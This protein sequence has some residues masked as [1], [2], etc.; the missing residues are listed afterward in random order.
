MAGRRLQMQ[1]LRYVVVLR[2]ADA[3]LPHETTAPAPRVSDRAKHGAGVTRPG[4][5]LRDSPNAHR[6]WRRCAYES[7]PENAAISD[8]AMFVAAP[9]I[10]N[11]VQTHAAGV[12]C[13]CADLLE[14]HRAAH[15]RR[16]EADQCGR[17]RAQ[18][19]GI[20]ATPAVSSGSR[21]RTGVPVA[22][23]DLLCAQPTEYG[24]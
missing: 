17:T 6:R 20:I 8:L 3:E 13:A 22:S 16:L 24:E 5:D 10:G 14:P 4:G 19:A 23:A 7:V 21:H 15:N 18:L 9:A 2:F 12:R 11:A 1:R